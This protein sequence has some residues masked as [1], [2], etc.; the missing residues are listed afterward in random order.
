[1]CV[2]EVFAADSDTGGFDQ[3]ITAR[4]VP[5]FARDNLQRAKGWIETCISQHR[6]CREFQGNTVHQRRRPTRVLEVTPTSVKLRCDMVDQEFKYLALSHMWGDPSVVHLKLLVSNLVDF[7]QSIPWH[8]LS[9]IYQEAIRVTL[10]LGYTF[11]WIDSLTIIQD[12]GHPDWEYEARL[13]ATVYGNA[14][15]NLAFLFPTSTS[16]ST[17]ARSDPRDW[18]P[19]I[20]REATPICPGVCIQHPTNLLRQTYKNTEDKDWLVQPNWPLFGR[21]WTFQEY[22]LCPRTLLLGHRNLMF[23]CSRHFYDELLGPL[24]EAPYVSRGTPYAGRAAD[25]SRYFPA[26]LTQDWD[27]QIDMS[28]LSALR[29]MTDWQACL[30]EYRSRN[31]SEAKDRIIAF[32]GVASAFGNMGALTYLAGCWAEYFPLTMLWYVGKKRLTTACNEAVVHE[33]PSWS[34]FSVPIST[35]HETLFLLNE[36]EA[37]S[38]MRFEANRVNPPSHWRDIYWSYLETFKF[39]GQPVDTVPESGFTDFAGLQITLRM[40]LLPIDM[41]W[42]E[43]SLQDIRSNS[44]LDADVTWKHKFTYFPD[45][46]SSPPSPPEPSTLALVSEFQLCRI[47]GQDNVDRRLAGL[48]LVP[49]QTSGTWKRIG[50][51]KLRVTIEIEKIDEETVR[52]VA[53]RWKRYRLWDGGSVKSV[54]LV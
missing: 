35:S 37:N 4:S 9:S 1:M 22:L 39:P 53:R 33:S 42:L 12:K 28:S 25:K 44:P 43:D 38:R 10:A 48:V 15:C 16:E 13:M 29:F 19:C 51:W 54:T 14:D 46:P 34:Q 30:K 27:K 26:S 6:E 11:I 24:T 20:L 8:D 52:I 50:A 40:P 32:A 2:N 31:L 18:N 5:R 36:D 17:P 3:H 41:S 23:Q 7:Q 47:P 49:G 21:A 45:D